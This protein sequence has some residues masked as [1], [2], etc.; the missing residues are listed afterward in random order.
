[1]KITNLTDKERLN[2]MNQ[3]EIL[4]KLSGLQG[5]QDDVKTFSLN[6]SIVKEKLNV[7]LKSSITDCSLSDQEMED[8]YEILLMY[9]FIQHADSTRKFPGFDFN[10][11]AGYIAV[12]DYFHSDDRFMD[13]ELI[14]SHRSIIDDY[15]KCLPVWKMIKEQALNDYNEVCF[16]TTM[17]PVL[18]IAP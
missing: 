6:L 10:H 7:H 12:I 2:L 11:D 8:L 3:Y 13:I 17:G 16:Q 1:M 15:I 18:K 9:S 14:N 5:N 4:V